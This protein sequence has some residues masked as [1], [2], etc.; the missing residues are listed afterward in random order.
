MRERRRRKEKMVVPACEESIYA[1]RSCLM[2]KKVWIKCDQGRPGAETRGWSTPN[3][4]SVKIYSPT[5][6]FVYGFASLPNDLSVYLSVYFLSACLLVF[7]PVFLPFYLS[8][9]YSLHFLSF[10]PF[11]LSW[12]FTVRC[13]LQSY[14]RVVC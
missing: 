1:N 13:Y 12:R 8:Y 11:S 9:L 5:K 7:L 14:A 6:D 4:E 2:K 3:F 10:L